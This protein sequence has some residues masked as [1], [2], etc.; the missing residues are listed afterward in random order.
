MRVRRARQTERAFLDG[1][2]REAR[3]K[4]GNMHGAIGLARSG[5]IQGHIEEPEKTIDALAGRLRDMS[6]ARRE[7]KGAV[8]LLQHALIVEGGISDRPIRALVPGDRYVAIRQLRF[9]ENSE[10]FRQSAQGR[11]VKH[12][13]RLR[14]NQDF[15]VLGLRGE[16]L[17]KIVRLES[18]LFAALAKRARDP[19]AIDLRVQT[20][21][22]GG[23]VRLPDKQDRDPGPFR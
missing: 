3:E 23:K 10:R 4:P 19:L 7:N 18:G 16:K 9:P 15:A 6:G 20:F 11:G 5:P 13:A 14:E 8:A 22:G 21:E 12:D 17:P 2:A 1:R